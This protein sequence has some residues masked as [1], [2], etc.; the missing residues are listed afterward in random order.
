MNNIINDLMPGDIIEK[1][2]INYF[3]LC[4][5]NEH[6]EKIIISKNLKDW[7]LANIKYKNI[8]EYKYI[9]HIKT[10]SEFYDKK[11]ILLRKSST[12]AD[13]VDGEDWEELD[14]TNSIT[15][16][17]WNDDELAYDQKDFSSDCLI[18]Q[19]VW[20]KKSKKELIEKISHYEEINKLSKNKSFFNTLKEMLVNES[21]SNLNVSQKIDDLTLELFFKQ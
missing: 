6:W 4:M 14:F 11:W 19:T 7:S 21:K 12:F 20:H 10:W 16:N 8:K 9:K 1:E 17:Y 18:N 13:V 15:T 2:K 3:I 5:T